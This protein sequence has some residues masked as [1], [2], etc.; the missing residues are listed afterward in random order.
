M[1]PGSPNLRSKKNAAWTFFV[2]LGSKLLILFCALVVVVCS[3]IIL[4][5]VH[6][7]SAQPLSSSRAHR[8]RRRR[9]YDEDA[10]LWHRQNHQLSCR[11][12][13][14]IGGSS[15]N[16]IDNDDDSEPAKC[17]ST[18][19]QGP[20]KHTRQDVDNL[21]RHYISSCPDRVVSCCNI[22]SAMQFVKSKR[23]RIKESTMEASVRANISGWSYMRQWRAKQSFDKFRSGRDLCSSCATFSWPPDYYDVAVP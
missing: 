20:N 4:L 19:L 23:W 2:M 11:K 14:R 17:S 12:R 16:N 22:T 1:A 15:C 13:R 6:C 18:K 7:T 9:R 3:L 8:Q 5:P 10:P 21:V